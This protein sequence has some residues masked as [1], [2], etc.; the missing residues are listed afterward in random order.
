M[1]T[2][3][4]SNSE[5]NQINFDNTGTAL[6]AADVQAAIEELDARSVFLRQK[7]LLADLT[8]LAGY[9]AFWNDLCIPMGTVVTIEAGGTLTG[10]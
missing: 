1:T 10:I 5:A 6:S 3:H 2:K 8:I 4:S 9:F 7:Q